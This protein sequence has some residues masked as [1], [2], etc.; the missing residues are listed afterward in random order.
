MIKKTNNISKN[1]LERKHDNTYQW[2]NCTN[3]NIYNREGTSKQSKGGGRD[4]TRYG[5]RY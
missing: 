4:K 5:Y 1:E 3:L 2:L